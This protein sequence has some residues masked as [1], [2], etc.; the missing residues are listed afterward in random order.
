MTEAASDYAADLALIREAALAA[1]ELA[2]AN[3]RPG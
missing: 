2:L 1:G 3:A